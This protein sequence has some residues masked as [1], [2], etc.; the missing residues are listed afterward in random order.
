MTN[1]TLSAIKLSGN[2]GADEYDKI[3]VARADHRMWD[4]S[5]KQLVKVR[6]LAMELFGEHHHSKTMRDVNERI[7]KPVCQKEKKSYVL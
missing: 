3:L 4:I 5:Y 7:I 2:K 6:D 1:K